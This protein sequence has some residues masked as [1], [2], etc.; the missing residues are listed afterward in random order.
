MVSLHRSLSGR[1]VRQA[2]TLGINLRLDNPSYGSL[3]RAHRRIL[4]LADGPPRTRPT[5]VVPS[6]EGD[7]AGSPSPSHAT[8]SRRT[9]QIGAQTPP[10]PTRPSA[11]VL[12]IIPTAPTR[13]C[14]L[15][16]CPRSLPSQVRRWTWV[17][18]TI[19]PDACLRP[20]SSD[21]CDGAHGAHDHTNTKAITRIYHYYVT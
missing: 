9:G 12:P 13:P 10:T 11:D 8:L 7:S 1:M 20:W 2:M 14:A 3:V 17:T 21:R 6:V 15:A 4:V 16:V 19:V 18:F 5:C